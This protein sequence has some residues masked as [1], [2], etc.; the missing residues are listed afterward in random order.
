[1]VWNANG[2]CM[3]EEGGRVIDF[4]KRQSNL[5]KKMQKK[6][7]WPQYLMRWSKHDHNGINIFDKRDWERG[8]A[9]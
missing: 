1:M 2:A 6:K 4:I 8:V 5:N 9:A 3:I 7:G